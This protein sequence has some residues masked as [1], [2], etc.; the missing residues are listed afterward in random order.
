M[1]N[2]IGW[3]E[4][5]CNNKN[6]SN[7]L[8]VSRQSRPEDLTEEIVF[9]QSTL[10]AIAYYRQLVR[11]MAHTREPTASS[12]NQ[13]LAVK[14][15]QNVLAQ[16]TTNTA[17]PAACAERYGTLGARLRDAFVELTIVTDDPDAD[18]V[19]EHC[20]QCDEPVVMAGS[21]TC[22]AGHSLTRCCISA[23]LVPII[24][25]H[26]CKQCSCVALESVVELQHVMREMARTVFMCPVCDVPLDR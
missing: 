25:T 6:V 3:L 14:C 2:G 9:V 15:L 22:A 19:Y 24:S 20:N 18:A 21:T 10:L 17:V 26:G 12:D 7:P 11:L 23:M 4:V 8:D 1:G 13:K 16:Y 5:T